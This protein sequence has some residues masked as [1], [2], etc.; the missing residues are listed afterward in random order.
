MRTSDSKNIMT[1]K[2]LF[3]NPCSSI[4]MEMAYPEITVKNWPVLAVDSNK[5]PER[6]INTV[7]ICMHVN[8]QINQKPVLDDH[9]TTLIKH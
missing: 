7:I 5:K 3:N 8:N 6:K 9:E 2:G 1:A 4:V